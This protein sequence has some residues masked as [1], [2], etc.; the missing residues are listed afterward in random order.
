MCGLAPSGAAAGSVLF[1]E[2]PQQS[3]ADPQATLQ[4]PS[5]AGTESPP[6]E[7]ETLPAVPLEPLGYSGEPGTAAWMLREPA[8]PVP[9]RWR[10]GWLPWDR[11]GRQAPTDDLLMNWSGGDSPYTRGHGFNPYDRNILKGDY[12]IVGDDLFLNVSAI[13]DTFITARKLPTPSGVSAGNPGSFDFFGDGEQFFVNQNFILSLE[14]FQGYTA[15]RPVD[16]LVRV[17]PVINLNHLE[18]Q[19]H[20]AAFIDTRRGDVRDDHFIA[21]QEAF[22]ELHLGDTSPNFDIAALRLGRQQFNS[23]F[24]GFIFND[25]SDGVRLLGNFESN[26]I[27]YNLALFNQ[28]EKDTNSQ[29]DELEWRDQQVFIANLYIQDFIWKGYTTQFS[30]HWNHDRSDLRYD[31]NGFLVR[32]SLIGSVTSQE[33]DAYYLGWASDGHIGRINVN[34]ALYY[35]L[36]QDRRNPIAGRDVDISAFLGAVELSYDM[37]WLRPKVSL[38][39]ASG[40]G[41][42]T[43]GRGEGFDGIFDNPFFAGGPGSFYQSQ[44]LRLFG[45]DLTS[46]RSLYNDLAGT[47]AEGQSNFVNPGIALINAGVDAEITPKLRASLNANSLWFASTDTLELVLNQNGIGSHIGEELNLSAQY[48]PAL[49]NNIIL[50]LGGSLFF[51]GDGFTDIY[52]SDD[53]LWQVFAGVTLAF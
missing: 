1:Q 47:K 8:V 23:D 14:L 48:R 17:T 11:Y 51:P 7:T 22:G 40:D 20:N 18:L 16:W 45:V 38:L 41:D 28:T 34:H 5:P 19:E 35:V 26:R 50:T 2:P 32:P 25:N 4:E 42:P 46:A 44:A 10:I 33:I 13:S 6:T 31:E 9:D 39:Y 29:L 53:T 43:D 27:Q 49:N 21:L 12:P 3:A 37:D 24:R 30:F 15:F 36:G 52:E